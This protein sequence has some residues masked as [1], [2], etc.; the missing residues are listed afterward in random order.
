MANEADMT[1]HA[2]LLPARSSR[3][4]SYASAL[5]VLTLMLWA[6]ISAHSNVIAADAPGGKVIAEPNVLLNGD[7]H[8]WKD[9]KGGIT[10]ESVGTPPNSLPLHWYG[11]PG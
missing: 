5:G 7:F 10:T 4:C 9:Y 2:R 1:F 11:G 6:T 3:H 8:E